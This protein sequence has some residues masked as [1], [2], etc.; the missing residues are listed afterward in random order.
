MGMK[1]IIK[2]TWYVHQYEKSSIDP[3]MVLLESVNGKDLG[4]NML[5][6]MVELCKP[7]YAK[8]KLYFS[9]N[10]NIEERVKKLLDAYG[11]Q[12]VKIVT[13]DSFSYY[14]ILAKAGYLFN[15][16]TFPR[17]FLKKPG[18][19]YVNTWHG[20][21]LKRMGADVP[22]GAHVIGNIQRNFFMCDYLCL[23]NKYTC[24][25]FRDAYHI[26]GLYQGE[27]VYAGY[28]RNQVF[29]E[30]ERQKDVRET[31][32][33]I[34]E[35][36]RLYCYMPTWRGAGAVQTE[37]DKKKQAES[38]K[39]Y[40]TQ[41][42]QH[43]EDHEKLMIRLH[44]FLGPLISCENYKHIFYMPDGLDPYEAC[45]A[46]DCLITDYSS[47][48][49][50]YACKDN[51]K[52]LLFL[53]ERETYQ[54]ERS[55]YGNIED[56][57]F[58]A[59]ETVPDLIKELRTEK[60]YDDREFLDTYCSREGV[61]SAKRICDLV[62]HGK[63]K[64]ERLLIEKEPMDQKEKRL[65]YAGGLRRTGITSAWVNLMENLDLT[66]ADYYVSFLEENLREDPG[67]LAL[68]PEGV[69]ILA[70]SP[71]WFLTL[72]EAAAS[73]FYYKK[74]RTGPWIQKK[75]KNFYQREYRRTYGWI[76]LDVCM[77][78]SGYERKVIGLYQEANCRRGI[79]IHSNMEREISLRKNQHRETLKEAYRQ[80]DFAIAVSKDALEAAKRICPECKDLRVIPN[81]LAW[82]QVLAKADQPVV[83]ALETEC[84]RTEEELA[85]WIQKAREEKKEG[86]D[87]PRRFV[88]VGRFSVEK[89]HIML[90]NAFAKYEKSHPQ[91]EL[92]IIGGAGDLYESTLAR[93]KELAVEDQ[94][95]LLKS[96]ANPMPPVAACD[97]FLLPSSHEGQP[98][99]F[100]EADVLSVP[101]VG[102]KVPGVQ[103][104]ME[105]HGGYLFP[106]GEDGIL[107]AMEAY[108]R[109]EIRT[110]GIDYARWNGEAVEQFE[111]ILVE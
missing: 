105:E 101:C 74:N 96:V 48:F 42:D 20:T 111:K 33:K 12:K 15:D 38:L 62:F 67:R 49:Y 44:P 34:K 75:L 22:G 72:E 51:G 36:E 66:K 60:N 25:I 45:A 47:V 80:Y 69:R 90:L 79:M 110:L 91:A 37:E 19:I 77:H 92:V 93:A 9:C 54:T 58:P 99:V 106:L 55:I 32:L 21:P 81:C 65:F 5:R 26:R 104:F 82:Q 57:P 29:F 109:G 78:Y 61:D 30:K 89:N 59:V 94:V 53:F 41:M 108:D 68:L 4:N 46:S 88:S 98:M 73:Y 6:I 14:K 76:A 24:E 52:I 23:P 8:L 7:E 31:I 13:C 86:R 43:L 71:G 18:Q 56:L 63:R 84:N 3:D 11:L 35:G 27:Y 85:A 28:P 107:E 102:S 16:S 83:F 39:K 100:M 17:R 40:L 70:I 2:N 64:Q 95:I 87:H 103:E 1:A 97:L 10:K 50:D